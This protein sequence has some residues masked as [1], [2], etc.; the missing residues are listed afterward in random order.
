[1]EPACDNANQYMTPS[2]TGETTA[3]GGPEAAASKGAAHP[4]MTAL[5]ILGAVLVYY[6]LQVWILPAAGVRT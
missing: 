5:W 4:L 3:A 6:A 2:D 1:M